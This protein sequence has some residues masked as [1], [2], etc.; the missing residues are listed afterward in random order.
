MHD[1]LLDLTHSLVVAGGVIYYLTYIGR[2]LR[3]GTAAE[4]VTRRAARNL[5]K[6]AQAGGDSP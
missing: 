1:R 3:G 5:A 6:W 2:Q 4:D